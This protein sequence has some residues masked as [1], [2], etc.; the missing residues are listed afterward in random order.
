RLLEREVRV[1]E[2]AANV[3]R[4]EVEQTR[5]ALLQTTQ[6]QDGEDGPPLLIRAPVDGFVLN[7]MEE[8]A[9]VVSP[10]LPIMEIGDPRNLEAEIELL[11]VDAVGVAPGAEATIEHWGG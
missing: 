11:S 9:R 10:G 4:F 6:L 7:V 2:F 8:S 3:A 5:A 1:A